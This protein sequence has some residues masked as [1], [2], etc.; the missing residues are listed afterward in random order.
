MT[1][2]KRQKQEMESKGEG[3]GDKEEGAGYLSWEE[4][5]RL[6]LSRKELELALSK[7]AVY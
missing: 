2:N 6:S 3:E 5:R 4:D 1:R 7:I